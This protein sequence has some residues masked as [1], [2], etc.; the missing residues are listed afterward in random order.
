MTR[1]RTMVDLSALS[2]I[3]KN[4]L[5]LKTLPKNPTSM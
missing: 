5:L 4:N 1:V 3:H 2:P